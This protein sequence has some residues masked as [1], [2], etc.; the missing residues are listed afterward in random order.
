MGHMSMSG[1]A[2][3]MAAFAELGVQRR[4]SCTS[5][6][7]TRSC[8][9]TAPE[10]ARGRARRLGG[11]LRR[12]GDR[13][14]SPAAD[15]R[16]AGAPP[17]PSAPSAITTSTRSIAC[18]TA[19]SSNKGQ[20]Q[21]WALN[22]Y[23]YQAAMP[24]KD[25]ALLSRAHDRELRREW[26]TASSTTTASGRRGGRHRALAGADRCAWASTAPTSIS[27]RGAL[28]ATR[29]AVEAYVRFVRERTLLEAV[30]S[31]LTELFAPAIHRERISGML[32]N[33]DFIGERAMEYFRRRL[34]QA[35]P[36]RRLRARLRQAARAHA[37]SSSRPAWTRCASS[38]TC[39]GRSSTRCY[40]R[41]RR[42]RPD[43]AR[44]LRAG[45]RRIGRHV[46]LSGEPTAPA[47]S[48]NCRGSR[49]AL[50]QPITL[51]E[52][53]HPAGRGTHLRDCGR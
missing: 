25:A 36:R 38:A 13:A 41:L 17:A 34:D 23:C 10:R 27:M 49:L 50:L 1:P 11:R 16:R 7:P 45:A 9:R 48:L 32:E 15:A 30:A 6:T 20:V 29:F 3:S 4:S 53:A 26:V 44:R 2:G 14:V 47:I 28:P 52:L 37:A 40:S 35:P 5:T 39:C 46:V 51:R 43:S 31:S 12:H 22:R 18:C 8:A 21:A 19:A 33:Y 42:S 24:R